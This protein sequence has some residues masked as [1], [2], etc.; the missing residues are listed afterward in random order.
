MKSAPKG[1]GFLGINAF[2]KYLTRTLEECH[3]TTPSE[4]LT[5]LY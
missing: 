3:P 4:F 5:S 2:S 1:A